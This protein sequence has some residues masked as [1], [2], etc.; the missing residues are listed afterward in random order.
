MI[1]RVLSRP[2]LAAGFALAGLAVTR[3][4]DGAAAAETVAQLAADAEVGIVL[5]DDALYQALPRELLTRLDRQALPIVA[6]I[7]GPRWDERSEAEA[8]I[9]EILR[10]AIGYRVRPR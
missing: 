9:L 2:A 6:P 8:Y 10:Q 7:P 5:V 1:V 4:S 3:V